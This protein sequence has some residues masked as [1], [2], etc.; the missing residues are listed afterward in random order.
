MK[1]SF[2]P[3]YDLGQIE[4]IEDRIKRNIPIARLGRSKPVKELL[5]TLKGMVDSCEGTLKTN[6]ELT[7]EQ[8]NDVFTQK[9]C[10]NWLISYF[11]VAEKAVK[12]ENKKVDELIEENKEIDEI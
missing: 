5:A 6:R 12:E 7:T 8:R 2:N 4:I 1:D 3:E 10:W 9:D 11:E